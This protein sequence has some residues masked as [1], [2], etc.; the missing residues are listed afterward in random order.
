M[1]FV[2]LCLSLCV[3]TCGCTSYVVHVAL[4]VLESILH[5]RWH[6]D[7]LAHGFASGRAERMKSVVEEHSPQG[8][9]QKAFAGQTLETFRMSLLQ[10]QSASL[11]YCRLVLEMPRQ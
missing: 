8:L 3:C 4:R 11:S 2:R 6:R 7:S 5:A 9:H 1:S 10:S